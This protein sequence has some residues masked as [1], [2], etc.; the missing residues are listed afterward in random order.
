MTYFKTIHLTP[1]K[2]H[3]EIYNHGLNVRRGSDCM[4]EAIDL[5][6]EK[7]FCVKD[8]II[9]LSRGKSNR[10]AAATNM[11]EY[12]SRSHMALNV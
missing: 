4:I 6:K 11:N 3:I 7:V 2:V 9:I 8:V 1:L 12:S 5:K 10:A